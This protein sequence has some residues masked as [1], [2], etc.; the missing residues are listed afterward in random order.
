[1]TVSPAVPAPQPLLTDLR[2]TLA[3]V[4]ELARV[5]R[6]VVSVWRRRHAAGP[7]PFPAPVRR[8]V[9]VPGRSRSDALLFRASD[10]ADWIEASGLGNN[11]AFRADVALRAMLD[12]A[13]GPDRDVAFAGLT[14]LLRLKAYV[15]EPL[16]SLDADDVLD[17]ADELDPDDDALY[18]EVE[19]L[20][21]H[22]DR[23]AALADLAAG[24]A[25][26]PGAAVEALLADRFRAGPDELLPVGARTRRAR[27][28]RG[29]GGCRR[30][31]PRGVGRDGGA[32]R[33]RPAPGLRGPPGRRPRPRRGRRV[34][35]GP[36]ADGRRPPS[37]TPPARRARLVRAAPGD[38]ARRR[39][40]RVARASRSW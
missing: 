33:R 15:S 6:P 18:A 34:P 26:T 29:P 21:D 7:T 40:S 25:Y 17:L 4:A 39:C 9:A 1:M 11:R 32:R 16:G 35:D 2:L 12:D 20:G 13:S 31:R 14:A 36:R 37:G 30:G 3:D 28:R 23:F 38:R 24:S 5:R 8:A 10:V 22:L 27:A 19:A